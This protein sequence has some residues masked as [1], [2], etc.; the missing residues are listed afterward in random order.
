M[1]LCTLWDHA[2]DSS[3]TFGEPCLFVVLSQLHVGRAD[4]VR[5][6][7]Y[8][9]NRLGLRKKITN[10][11]FSLLLRQQ[12]AFLALQYT[13]HNNCEVLSQPIGKAHVSR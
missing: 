5:I 7:I 4:S 3:D 13:E 2:F 10:F 6:A 1:R 9:L 11:V 8:A 12:S